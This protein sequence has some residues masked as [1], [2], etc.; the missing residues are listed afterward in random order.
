MARLRRAESQAKT[1]QKLLLA[2]RDV[3][4]STG[5]AAASIDQIVEKAGFS[6]GAFYSNFSSKEVVFLDL[7]DEHMYMEVSELSRVIEGSH[8][9]AHLFECLTGF[10]THF[11]TDPAMCVLSVE[12]RLLAMRNAAAHE[13]FKMLWA[14][15]RCE[16]VE[17]LQN[18]MRRFGVSL[19]M[20]EG[21]I[22]DMLTALTHGLALRQAA[23][24][25]LPSI[26][27]SGAVIGVLQMLI[28]T[29]E[30]VDV[31]S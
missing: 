18:A 11:F 15:Q 6:K 17:R 21:E 25:E 30:T 8:S 4:V 26:Q 27:T 24:K 23:T 31:L 1:R 2:A 9:V 28:Q 5:I 12:F 14:A 10:Y 3:V 7:F 13:R 29:K 22:I 19:K 20:G 16:L